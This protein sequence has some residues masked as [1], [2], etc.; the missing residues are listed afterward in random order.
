MKHEKLFFLRVPLLPVLQESKKVTCILKA[1]FG[2][3]AL[4]LLMVVLGCELHR[5]A[6]CS[7]TC[8]PSP[9]G[10]GKGFSQQSAQQTQTVLHSLRKTAVLRLLWLEGAL[11][12]LRK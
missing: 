4:V 1:T 10:D 9:F 11:S 6:V 8:A 5:S 12:S 7:W 2:D 3:T